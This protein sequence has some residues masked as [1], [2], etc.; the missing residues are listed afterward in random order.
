[1]RLNSRLVKDFPSRAV[2]KID[3]RALLKSIPDPTSP[4]PGVTTVSVDVLSILGSTSSTISSDISVFY[5]TEILAIIQRA[6]VKSSGLVDTSIW[7]WIGKDAMMG[8]KE[9]KALSDLAKRY[10]TKLVGVIIISSSSTN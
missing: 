3:V 9:E 4:D 1:M 7:G 10:G 6:K 8:P 2:P 5:D